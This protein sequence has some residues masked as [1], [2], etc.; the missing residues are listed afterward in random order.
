VFHG[1]HVLQVLNG[2]L[3]GDC[4]EVRVEE[5][6]RED[7]LPDTMPPAGGTQPIYRV[8]RSIADWQAQR[9]PR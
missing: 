1:A 9:E 7:G 3:R 8:S 6:G 4:V 2:V 5:E